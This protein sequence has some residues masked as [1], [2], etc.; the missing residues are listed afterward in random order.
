MKFKNIHNEANKI[1][2]MASAKT[3]SRKMAYEKDFN[4]ILSKIEQE[5]IDLSKFII[6]ILG[7]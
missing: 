2:S 7:G 1:K 3:G 6:I 5:D 4:R